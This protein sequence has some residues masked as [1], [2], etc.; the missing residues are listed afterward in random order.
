MKVD[1]C[2]YFGKIGKPKGFKGEVNLIIS[3]DCPFTPEELT[4]VF[5]QV[6]NK[7]VNYPLTKYIVSPKGNALGKFEDMNSD[8]D[9]NRIKNMSLYLSK[10]LLPQLDDDEFYLHDVV[11][12]ILH[13]ETKGEIGEILEINTQTAQTIL[14]VD[15]KGDEIVIPFVEDFIVEINTKNNKVILNLP[16]GLID[17]N[18]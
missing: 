12:C 2:F 5:V 6:G 14:F 3:K 1:D 18:E 10:E 11:G 9:V 15:F 16:P 8:I 13:D 17:L 4:E 7:L